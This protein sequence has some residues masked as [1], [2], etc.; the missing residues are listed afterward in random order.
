MSEMDNETKI[1]DLLTTFLQHYKHIFNSK[2][3][4]LESI[5]TKTNTIHNNIQ[6]LISKLSTKQFSI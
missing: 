4:L 6:F 2:L 5:L 1:T 3:S